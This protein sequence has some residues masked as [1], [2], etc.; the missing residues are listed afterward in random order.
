M[1]GICTF[2]GRDHTFSALNFQLARKFIVGLQ[3]LQGGWGMTLH[4][5]QNPSSNALLSK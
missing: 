1:K 5:V 2:T 3:Q 4:A